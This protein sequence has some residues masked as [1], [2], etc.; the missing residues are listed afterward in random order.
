MVP[1]MNFLIRYLL[2]AVFALSPQPLLA[3]DKLISVATG[4]S[5]G[6]YMLRNGGGILNDIIK[7]SLLFAGYEV[8]FEYLSNAAAI[9]AFRD[10]QHDAVTVVKPGMVD[11]YLS[12]PVIT[13]QNMVISLTDNQ[14]DIDQLADLAGLRVIAFSEASTLLGEPLQQVIPN[15]QSYREFR[16]QQAQVEALY[17]G[18]TDV[19]IA[20]QYIFQ[21]F[22]KR[23]IYQNLDNRRYARKVTYH[24]KFEP[25]VYHIAFRD[26]PV[27]QAFDAGFRRL[28]E[29]GRVERIYQYHL[30]LLQ[31]Y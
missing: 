21:F 28:K 7:E 29:F 20:D 1:V 17:T 18:Q 25:S 13:F 22:R 16:D 3:A 31:G 10:G 5:L 11:G 19:I 9:E 8:R 26:Q 2:L 27:Q 12:Q 30:E 4:Y 23:L 24:Y 15:M 14:L 6:P